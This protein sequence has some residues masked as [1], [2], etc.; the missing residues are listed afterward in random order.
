MYK[1][2][3]III[4]LLILC[5]Y[6]FISKPDKVVVSEKGKVEGIINKGRSLLQGDRF[7]KYQ[8]ALASELYNKNNSPRLP[9]SAE[10]QT[11]YRKVREDQRLLDEKMKVL[12]TQDEQTARLLRMKADSLELV[13]KWKSID[14]EAEAA[15]MQEMQKFKIIIPLLE[16]RLHIAKPQPVPVTK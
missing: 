13:S 12:Y 1:A 11:L 2:V 10:M 8:F 16:N 7:W 4:A 15:R 3:V 6:L 9:S 14:D 5:G